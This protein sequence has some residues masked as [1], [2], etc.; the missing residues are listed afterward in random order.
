[1]KQIIALGGSGFSMEPENPLL[2]LYICESVPRAKKH[3][4]VE[5]IEIETID[6]EEKRTYY[7]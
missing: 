4:E 7:E 3:Q 6:L 1:M 2:D 5:E